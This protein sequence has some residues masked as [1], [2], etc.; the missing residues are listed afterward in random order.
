MTDDNISITTEELDFGSVTDSD[1]ST[2]SLLDANS[3]LLH[4]LQQQLKVLQNLVSQQAQLISA[5]AIKI[6]VLTTE[7]TARKGEIALATLDRGNIKATIK[8]NA[9]EFNEH[10]HNTRDNNMSFPI[11]GCGPNHNGSFTQSRM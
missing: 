2:S 6:N 4:D 9:K 3:M 10:G 8:N 7:N 11:K 1:S 5:Q